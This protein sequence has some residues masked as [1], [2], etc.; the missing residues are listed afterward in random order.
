MIK[1][2]LTN[3]CLHPKARQVAEQFRAGV[4]TRRDYLAT[5]A[6]LGVSA[7]GAFALGGIA[8]T[9]AKAQSPQKGGVLRV[10]M[11]V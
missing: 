9:P 7:A 2:M 4:M 11:N 1:F 5:M 10:A 8:P 3:R 6:A